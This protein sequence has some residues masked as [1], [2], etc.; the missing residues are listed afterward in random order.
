[1]NRTGQ[2]FFTVRG[3]RQDNREIPVS[4]YSHEVSGCFPGG[5]VAIQLTRTRRGVCNERKGEG[6]GNI[7]LRC[8]SASLEIRSKIPFA[9]RFYRITSSNLRP[10][11]PPLLGEG[12]ERAGHAV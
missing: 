4:P 7:N 12:Q 3:T 6:T 2:C 1:M 11:M 10:S 9:H 5:A 8:I